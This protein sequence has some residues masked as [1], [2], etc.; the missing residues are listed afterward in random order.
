MYHKRGTNRTTLLSALQDGVNIDPRLSPA[1]QA[2][3]R[4]KILPL[5]LPRPAWWDRQ[6]EIV[7]RADKLGLPVP[8]GEYV[9]PVLKRVPNV[10]AQ[11]K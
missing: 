4:Y 8:P 9:R 10:W 3:E 7:E 6:H 5:H 2:A 1:E 11:K